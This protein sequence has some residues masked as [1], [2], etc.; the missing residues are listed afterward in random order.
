L[1]LEP[2]EATLAEL[3]AKLDEEEGIYLEFLGKIDRLSANPAPY[4]RDL[5]IP[6]LLSELN[7]SVAVPVEGEPAPAKGL[8]GLARR[9]ARKLLEPELARLESAF[10]RKREFDSTLVQFLNRLSESANA[11]GARA[12]EFASALVG[13]AQRIDRLADAKDRLYASL[14]NRR[15]DSFWNRWTSASRRRVSGSGESRSGSRE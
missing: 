1:E 15:S 8:K 5:R 7:R 14:G 6:E 3:E 10:A 13:F 2:T 4:Q 9:I 12:A 11:S